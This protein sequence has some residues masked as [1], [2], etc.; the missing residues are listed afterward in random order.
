MKP[1]SLRPLTE[2]D[3]E[4]Y[5]ECILE[6]LKLSPAAFL[7]SFDDEKNKTLAEV[8]TFLAARKI[9]NGN[10][11]FGAFVDGVLAGILG[12]SG[13]PYPKKKHKIYLSGMYVRKE[14]RRMGLGKRLLHSAI[15]FARS[16]PPIQRIELAVESSNETAKRLYASTGFEKWGTEP[17]TFIVKGKLY[18]ADYLSLSLDRS[19]I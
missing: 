19:S 1:V 6:G 13:M 12:V 11:V 8:R 7:L 16:L 4:Q 14:F 17:A 18:D 9:E 15:E 10:P 5:N 2:E 3:V